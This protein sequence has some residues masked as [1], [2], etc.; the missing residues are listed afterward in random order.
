MIAVIGAGPAG[1]AAAEAAARCGAAVTIIDSSQR[2]GGQYWR[3]RKKVSGYKSERADELLRTISAQQKIA[4]IAAA[5]VWSVELKNDLYQINYLHAGVEKALIAEK[6]NSCYR[7]LRP[8]A[9]ISGLGFTWRHDS[10]CSAI[11][12]QGSGRYCWKAH[13]RVGNGTL[14]SPCCHF[15][16]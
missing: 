14:P 7:R 1:L 16:C 15:S 3:H 6:I 4:H 11:S 12:S 10:R 5:T 9:S 8:F 2:M 13:C